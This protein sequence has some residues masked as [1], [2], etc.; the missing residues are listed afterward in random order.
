MAFRSIL[1]PTQVTSFLKHWLFG[2]SLFCR[3][4]K[5]AL[6]IV[7]ILVFIPDDDSQLVVKQW[8]VQPQ[9]WN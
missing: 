9:L 5:L 1:L 7:L 4:F 8:A 2:V 3:I 6:F